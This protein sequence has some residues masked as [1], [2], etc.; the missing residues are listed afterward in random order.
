MTLPPNISLKKAR[1][2]RIAHAELVILILL[3]LAAIATGIYIYFTIY[4][5]RF[6]FTPFLLE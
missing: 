2:K 4:D 3:G 6:S 1:A 5:I